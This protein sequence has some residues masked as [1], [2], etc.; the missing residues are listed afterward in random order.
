MLYCDWQHVT[1]DWF[2]AS[3]DFLKDKTNETSRKVS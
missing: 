3:D 1:D 2:N